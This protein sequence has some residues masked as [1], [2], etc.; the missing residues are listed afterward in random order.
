VSFVSSVVNA[1]GHRYGHVIRRPALMTSGVRGCHEIAVGRPRAHR[2]V[3]VD[4]RGYGGNGKISSVGLSAIN[5]VAGDGWAG[6][7]R[8]RVPLQQN[9][10]GPIVGPNPEKHCARD[11]NKK[12][13]QNRQRQ[14]QC[15][16]Q[17]EIVLLLI[18]QRPGFG[19]AAFD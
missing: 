4:G 15:S 6:S 11:P 13:R 12:D 7:G 18:H 16:F 8:R 14:T 9:A 5:L 2:T 1:L 19:D 3:K 10:V 17:W